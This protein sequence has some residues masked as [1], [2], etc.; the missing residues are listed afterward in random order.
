MAATT[1]YIRVSLRRTRSRGATC[2]WLRVRF[3]F[4]AEGVTELLS[5]SQYEEFE[6][7]GL[8]RLPGAIPRPDAALMCD[9]IWDHLLAER[10]ISRTDRATWPGDGRLTGLQSIRRDEA[11]DRIG[12]PVLRAALDDLLGKE[13]WPQPRTWGGPLI[14]F[15][16]PDSSTWDVPIAA[17]HNDFWPFQP[18]PGLRAVQL[19]ALLNEIRP[20]GGGTLVLSGSYRLVTKYADPTEDGPHPRKLRRTLATQHPWLR[21]LWR[22][23]SDTTDRKRRFMTAGTVID[24]VPLRVVELC[25]SPGDIFLMHCDTFHA[26]A[27]NCR[28]QPRFMATTMIS[29]KIS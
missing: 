7:T 2:P 29:R 11:L 21:E 9:R 19:F 26:V 27:R 28:D 17:W 15:P 13:R 4:P 23:G 18:E 16:N 1:E 5:A 6:R 25:G 14:T 12:S 22:D 3:V 10:G 20:Q 8:L 24:D